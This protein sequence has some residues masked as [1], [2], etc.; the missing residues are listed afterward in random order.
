MKPIQILNSINEEDN[1]S[2]QQLAKECAVQIVLE[3]KRSPKREL[4]E[5]ATKVISQLLNNI[6][7]NISEADHIDKSEN[8][9]NASS[10]FND[11]FLNGDYITTPSGL[12]VKYTINGDSHEIKIDNNHQWAYSKDGYNWVLAVNRKP[13]RNVTGTPIEVA[14]MVA[15]L[16]EEQHEAN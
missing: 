9:T 8:Y 2:I 5:I 12:V 3:H 15:D 4:V 6:G 16:A 1:S 7:Y 10:N 14:H 13:I 11:I